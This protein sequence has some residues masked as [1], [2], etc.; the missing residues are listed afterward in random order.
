MEATGEL[1]LP[2]SLRQPRYRH[3]SRRRRCSRTGSQHTGSVRASF[4]RVCRGP[5]G[6]ACMERSVENVGDPL[7][8]CFDREAPPDHK[9]GG[10]RTE[11]ESDPP[12]VLG[13]RESRLRGEG[14]DGVTESAQETSTGHV[15]LEHRGHPHCRGERRKLHVTRHTDVATCVGFSVSSSSLGAGGG[16]TRVPH[17]A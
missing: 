13:E 17:Q 7:G 12:R 16:C 3:S 10:L 14:A 5:Q 1:A 15:G 9:E 11:R 2:R 6:V 8:P 4:W